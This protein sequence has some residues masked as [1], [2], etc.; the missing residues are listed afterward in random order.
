MGNKTNQRRWFAGLPFWRRAE[1]TV[2]QQLRLK[3]IP[4][5]LIA[6]ENLGHDIV[7]KSDLRIEVKAA[8]LLRNRKKGHL[9]RCPFFVAGIAR[10]RGRTHQLNES[11]DF[12]VIRL[13]GDLKTYLVL[14]APLGVKQLQI[15]YR[16][17]LTKFRENVEAWSMIQRAEQRRAKRITA[18]ECQLGVQSATRGVDA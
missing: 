18:L 11:C 8:T 6:R 10:P 14:P 1:R 9:T 3:G 12:Y 7:T 13:L 4:C 15:T 17:L 2:A 16:M 5:K